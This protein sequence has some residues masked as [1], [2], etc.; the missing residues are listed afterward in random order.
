MRALESRLAMLEKAIDS[1]NQFTVIIR[2]IVSPAYLDAETQ[3]F[4]SIGQEWVRRPDESEVMLKDRALMEVR[5]TPGAMVSLIAWPNK[6][7][8]AEH[9]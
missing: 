9:A 4:T 1:A 5:R 7:P 8:E 2:K 3:R 6:T